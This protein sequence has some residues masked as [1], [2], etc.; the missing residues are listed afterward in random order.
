MLIIDDNQILWVH[1]PQVSLYEA[2]N[3]ARRLG[4][5]IFEFVGKFYVVTNDGPV[6][7]PG[8]QTSVKEKYVEANIRLEPESPTGSAN[9][10]GDEEARKDS[11]ETK[12]ES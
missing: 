1:S 10:E 6:K 3:I 9:T 8:R 2:A 12:E 4:Y 7:I 5:T 11:G